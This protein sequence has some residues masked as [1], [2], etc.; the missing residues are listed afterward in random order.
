MAEIS[1]E[2]N[3]E[4]LEKLEDGTFKKKNPATK[5]SLVVANDDSNLE[6]NKASN[7]QEHIEFGQAIKENKNRKASQTDYGNVKIGEGI[8]VDNGL[9]SIYVPEV[10]SSLEP[11]D[12]RYLFSGEKIIDKKVPTLIA[13]T[14]SFVKGKI[15]VTVKHKSLGSPTI[16]YMQIYING[17]AAGEIK[18]TGRESYQTEEMEVD[19]EY[20]DT[21]EL[22][23]WIN[24]VIY[25]TYG[26]I[27]DFKILYKLV[28]ENLFI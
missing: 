10:E 4:M 15:Q 17:V 26:T 25:S 13:G 24:D 5:A 9:I 14:D 16:S 12:L 28:D 19:V 8:H 1:E 20:G 23:A 6:E 11:E 27:K 22:Y 18:E 3:I 2:V 21:V 7:E